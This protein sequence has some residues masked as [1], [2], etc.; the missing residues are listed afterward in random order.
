M[1]RRPAWR[2]L[3]WSEHAEDQTKIQAY[4][5][6]DEREKEIM[7]RLQQVANITFDQQQLDNVVNVITAHES[8]TKEYE[9]VV[10][11]L[12]KADQWCAEIKGEIGSLSIYDRPAPI[13]EERTQIFEQITLWTEDHRKY[14]QLD[15][16]IKVKEIEIEAIKQRVIDA[17]VQQEKNRKRND[18]ISTLH[19]V[20]DVLHTSQFPR[21]LILSYADVVTE[22]L[23][24]NLQLFNIPYTA[25]VADNFK[26][27]LLD[28]DGRVLPRVSGGQEIQVGICLHLALHAL[29]S[30]SFPL[31]IID[32]GTTH[33]DQNNRRIY[34]DIIKSL[35][36]KDKL[37]Q[38]II[39]DH[40]PLLSE[41]VD[42]VITL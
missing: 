2:L 1:V 6:A 5:R 15:V 10:A 33:L 36:T 12:N 29:F 23:Q 18:Y 25:R 9:L 11:K 38:I 31:M 3:T 8:Y 24:E 30:Q 34:F 4:L 13:Y 14:Q 35:K 7:Y 21:K 19:K 28:E 16:A 17:T 39:I 20:Y 27:E 37:K 41:V 42:Q 40:D 32:E 26:I 22:Y